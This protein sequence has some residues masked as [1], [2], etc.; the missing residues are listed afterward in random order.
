MNDVGKTS[1]HFSFK[2]LYYGS[3]RS[4]LTSILLVLSFAAILAGWQAGMVYAV[5][6]SACAH[7]LIYALS[8]IMYG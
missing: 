6:V 3:K 4:G 8:I 5:K 1:T 7:Q 2:C